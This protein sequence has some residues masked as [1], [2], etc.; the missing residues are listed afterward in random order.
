MY[1]WTILRFCSR[2]H[3]ET[4]L[5]LAALIPTTARIPFKSNE[6][7]THLASWQVQLDCEYEFQF[8]GVQ[9]R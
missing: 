7:P 8:L 3:F 1:P 2:K 6:I 5:Y 9:R 4:D